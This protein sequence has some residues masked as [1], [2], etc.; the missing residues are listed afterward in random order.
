MMSEIAQMPLP[1]AF[2][3]Q[4]GP[5]VRKWQFQNSG[6]KLLNVGNIT[7]DG[8]IDLEKTDRYLSVEEATGK[9]SHFLI[10]PG[11]LVIASSGISFDGDGFLRTKI[12]FVEEEHLP[13]C[14]NTSTIR[15]KPKKDG[16]SLSYLKHWFHSHEFRNQVSRLVT[17]SAQLNFGPSHLTSMIISIPKP[18]EQ[19]RIAAIL[20]KADAIRHKREQAL[21]L[22][23]DFLC[24]LFLDMFGDPVTN[25]KEL[26]QKPLS[27]CARFI[28][29]ATPSKANTA[30]WDG[31]FPWVS[32]KDMK[33]ELLY[34][35]QDH[36]SEQVFEQTNLKKI[37][38]GTPLIV[39][40][41]MILAHTVPMAVTACEVA[42]NQDIKAIEFEEG[43]DPIF[44]F[45][46]LRVQHNEI[47]GRVDTAAHGTKRLDM[48]RLGE[49]PITLISKGSQK[50]F[51][52][53]VRKFGEF[54]E[55]IISATDISSQMFASLS[56]RAFR[57]EL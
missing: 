50:E 47:L 13:L 22:A 2:W 17:G 55:R 5:G 23:D 39:V 57:G 29:G 35:A 8:K 48:R 18:N 42:I 14:M 25:P 54:R 3:F 12:A 9:Y 24:S 46:C 11:D 19:C 44:G 40:R 10:D 56:K 28:S 20:D 38:L 1:E 51:L 21:K 4:E 37:P 27:K 15:F 16:F 26:D 7:P 34:D 52:S 31:I 41:G 6:I 49:V 43:I 30:Y 45:W 32:P 36:V 53:M 33:V